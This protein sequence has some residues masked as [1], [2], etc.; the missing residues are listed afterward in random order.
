MTRVLLS[1]VVL[2]SLFLAGSRETA[3]AQGRI[4]DAT[5]MEAGQRTPEISTAELRRILREHSATVFD[6]RPFKEYAIGHIPGALDVA[7]APGEPM[8]LYI[9]DVDE[10]SRVVHQKTD[11]PIVLYSDGPFS[12]KPKRLADHLLTEGYRNIRRYQLGMAVWRAL[13]GPVQIELAGAAF[14]MANDRSAVFIDARDPEEFRKR[15]LPEARNIPL[16]KIGPERNDSEIKTAEDDGRLPVEDH[17]TRIIV[18]GDN[19]EQSNAVAEA[20]TR[21]AYTNVA[22]FGG[23]LD[24]LYVAASADQHE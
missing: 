6:A 24:E 11:A 2:L 19:A 21:E 7:P 22:F 20:L 14:I 12:E 1:I 23:S 3:C 17:N 5:L 13:G 8:A 9:S 10:I 4:D 16:I 18:F 15:T